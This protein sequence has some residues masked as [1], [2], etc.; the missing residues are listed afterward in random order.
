ML[1]YTVLSM[2]DCVNELFLRDVEIGVMDC[3]EWIFEIWKW[4]CLILRD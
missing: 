4:R 2:L 3:G 1:I